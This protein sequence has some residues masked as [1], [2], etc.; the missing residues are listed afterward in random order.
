MHELAI[1]IG[2]TCDA[3]VFEQKQAKG[4]FCIKD[5]THQAFM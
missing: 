3:K 1:G 2:S 5:D 4:F